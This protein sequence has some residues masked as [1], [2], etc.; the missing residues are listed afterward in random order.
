MSAS[1]TVDVAGGSDLD[2][3]VSLGALTTLTGFGRYVPSQVDPDDLPDQEDDV[4][5]F[6]RVFNLASLLDQ[7]VDKLEGT[8]RQLVRLYED[9]NHVDVTILEG[10][11]GAAITERPRGGR[12]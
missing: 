8:G 2:D 6:L 1:R 4:D 10:P 11:N 12:Q 5:Q 9:R 7:M 3:A